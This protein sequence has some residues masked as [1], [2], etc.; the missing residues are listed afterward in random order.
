MDKLEEALNTIPLNEIINNIKMKEEQTGEATGFA[1][2]VV[3]KPEVSANKKVVCDLEEERY[4]Q[5]DDPLCHISIGPV[6]GGE[7]LSVSFGKATF[8]FKE[9][10]IIE[11]EYNAYYRGNPISGKLRIKIRE[12]VTLIDKERLIEEAE[13]QIKELKETKAQEK[14]ISD[15][16]RRRVNDIT[17]IGETLQSYYRAERK[18]FQS[19]T[20]PTGI[21]YYLVPAFKDPLTGEPYNWLDNTPGSLTGCDDQHFVLWAE[22]EQDILF[23]FIVA[24]EKGV[25][26]FKTQPTECPPK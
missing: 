10:D 23:K 11:G 7:P 13:R 24:S 16:D 9:N 2:I 5:R 3:K 15:R 22:L 19:K 17:L 6:G 14:E 25:K 26:A 1:V 21:K 20:M 18:Y 12:G 4:L 8:Y